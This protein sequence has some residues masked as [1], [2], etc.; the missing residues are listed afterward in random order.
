ME[1][2]LLP[3]F[4]VSKKKKSTYLLPTPSSSASLLLFRAHPKENMLNRAQ[5]NDPEAA[6]IQVVAELT[7]SY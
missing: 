2:M 7:R 5:V 3:P 6:D 1:A 4:T